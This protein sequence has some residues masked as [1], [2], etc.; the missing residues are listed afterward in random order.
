MHIQQQGDGRL[1]DEKLYLGEGNEG[2]INLRTTAWSRV[3]YGKNTANEIDFP[4][5]YDMGGT[6]IR[7]I[8]AD[9]AL[10]YVVTTATEKVAILQK[11]AALEVANFDAIDTWVCADATIKKEI[12]RLEMDG[13]VVVLGEE[14][15]T[16]A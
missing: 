4:G 5:E 8:D 3:R 16:E 11:A 7:C 9:D 10:H 13:D 12:E 2:A 6:T 1:F 15:T 14:A